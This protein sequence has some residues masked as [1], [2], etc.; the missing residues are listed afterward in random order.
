MH[1]ICAAENQIK[2]KQK[3]IKSRDRIQMNYRNRHVQ[4]DMYSD[5]VNTCT[6]NNMYRKNICISPYAYT[7]EIC[8]KQLRADVYTEESKKLKKRTV[9][10]IGLQWT[11]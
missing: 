11:F 8:I 9:F 4:S 5:N 6:S 1:A 10:F 7:D 2:Q 3:P